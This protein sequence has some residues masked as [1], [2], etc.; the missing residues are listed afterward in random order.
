[1]TGLSPCLKIF[2]FVLFKFQLKPTSS[3]FIE[4]CR[5]LLTE[6]EEENDLCNNFDLGSHPRTSKDLFD[7]VQ[8]LQKKVQKKCSRTRVSMT[9]G[10]INHCM[11]E[12][13]LICCAQ[14]F[15]C[16]DHWDK[17]SY[18]YPLQA[19]DFMESPENYLSNLT[20]AETYKTCHRIQGLDATVCQNDCESWNDGFL[21]K[22]CRRRGGLLKCCIRRDT[23]HCHECRYCC[24]LP[25]CT[26]KSRGELLHATEDMMMKLVEEEKNKRGKTG[27]EYKEGINP[28]TSAVIYSLRATDIFYKYL[29]QRC[30]KPDSLRPPEEWEHYVP[31]Q[32]VNALDQYD[33]DKSITVEYDNNFFNFVDPQVFEAFTNRSYKTTWKKTYGVDYVKK[34]KISSYSPLLECAK[35]CLKAESSKFAASCRSRGGIFK[36]CVSLFHLDTFEKTRNLLIKKNLLS[37]NTTNRCG[38]SKKLKDCTICTATFLCSN[39]DAAGVMSMRFMSEDPNPVGGRVILDDD[40]KRPKFDDTKALVGFP[41]KRLGLRLTF[42]HNLDFCT[43]TLSRILAEDFILSH[44]WESF[45]AS[46]IFRR[47]SDF[48]EAADEEAKSAHSRPDWE[49]EECIN[50]KSNVRICPNEILK[51][52]DDVRLNEINK[53]LKHFKKRLK[54]QNKKKKKKKSKRRH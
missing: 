53:E 2:I 43:M 37:G 17:I 39:R 25:F 9:K 23:A 3:R 5:L 35:E 46:K 30:L 6:H 38:K 31:Y 16:E 41:Y 51:Q 14:S 24:T 42:C 49:Q 44:N 11:T 10:S 52:E 15:E 13:T 21:A 33:L 50:N 19:I 54:K 18:E 40:I 7:C 20:S 28:L 26:W 12:D 8:D 4:D 47:H 32:F 45:C 1:M 36:C 22:E 27:N 34:V 29:D 48:K